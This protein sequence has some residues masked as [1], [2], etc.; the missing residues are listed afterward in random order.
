MKYSNT[1]IF[2]MVTGMGDRYTHK[3][4]YTL[5]VACSYNLEELLQDG[6]LFLLL[7][8][9]SGKMFQCDTRSVAPEMRLQTILHHRHMLI[10]QVAD[11]VMV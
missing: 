9:V 10:H 3:I 8:H 1:Y 11:R 4:K 2:P 7:L 6:N 5:K